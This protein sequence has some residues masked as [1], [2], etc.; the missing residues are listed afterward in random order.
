MIGLGR[1]ALGHGSRAD[2]RHPLLGPIMLG[3]AA[4][5]KWL[6]LGESLP[7]SPK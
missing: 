1:R 5:A 4:L 7:D 3:M 2:L 6:F